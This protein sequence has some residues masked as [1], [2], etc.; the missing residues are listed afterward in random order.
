MNNKKLIALIVGLFL[1]LSGW[2]SVE[3]LQEDLETSYY[4]L[5]YTS[6]SNAKQKTESFYKTKLNLPPKLPSLD[7]THSFARFNQ[8]NDNLEIEYLNNEQRFN[9]IINVFPSKIGVDKFVN[10]NAI[11]I[12]LKDGT[13]AYYS[14]SIGKSA[15]VITL[16]FEKNKW[17]Y[18]LSIQEDLLNN[19]L[20]ELEKIANS[21]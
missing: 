4:N 15:Q 13:Q 7:F 21:F 17:I 16:V 3:A 6:I 19:P 5:G 10:S 14:Y 8:D 2:H 11:Q 12:A 9:Y 20:S 1:C 18:L